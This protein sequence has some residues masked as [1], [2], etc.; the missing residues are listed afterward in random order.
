[1]KKVAV[2]TDFTYLPQQY[3]LVPAVL[4]QLRMMLKNGLKPDLIVMEG[5]ENHEDVKKVPDGV[6]V[7]S[8]IPFMHLFDYQFG[9]VEQ[10]HPVGPIG[11][12]PEDRPAIT[13]FKKQVELIVTYL[14]PELPKYDVIITHD[15]MFQTWKLIHNQAVR[16]IAKR[17]PDLKWLHWCHSGPQPRPDRLTFPHTLRF[18]GMNNA[19]WSR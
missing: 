1:M 2:L 15:I 4:S 19:L 13:N 3:G 6:E 9:T 7:K 18:T 11:E 10:K 8:L 14:E 16:E 5:F 12:K 17:H